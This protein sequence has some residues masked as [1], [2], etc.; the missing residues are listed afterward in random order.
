VKTVAIY[1]ELEK[2][3]KVSILWTEGLKKRYPVTVPKKNYHFI[4][5]LSKELDISDTT[6]NLCFLLQCIEEEK[7]HI[8]NKAK[9]ISHQK[10]RKGDQEKVAQYLRARKQ[11]YEQALK[12]IQEDEEKYGFTMEQWK[13]KIPIINTV[14]FKCKIH[15]EGFSIHHPAI[16]E[17]LLD[18]IMSE[19]KYQ[20]S[21]QEDFKEKLKKYENIN[22][23]TYLRKDLAKKVYDYFSNNT[24]LGKG[25]QNDRYYI[26][27]LIFQYVGVETKLDYKSYQ[28]IKDSS[29]YKN[30]HSYVAKCVSGRYF[31]S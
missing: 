1:P 31:R 12:E 25:S 6:D 22:G 29:Q 8:D 16:I 2:F 17:R 10:L 14:S 13:R 27:G 21:I 24:N 7:N 18:I 23:P 5:N 9:L 3:Q 26:I 30:Y 28:K 19:Y 4:L 20:S 11:A 15:K